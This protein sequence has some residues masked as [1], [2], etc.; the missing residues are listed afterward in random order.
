MK[1]KQK[2]LVVDD[3]ESFITLL[4]IGLQDENYEVDTAGNGISAL[5]RME[6]TSYDWLVSDIRMDE[7]DGIELAQ[8]VKER[9][10][11]TKIILMTAFD[12]PDRTGELEVEVVLE[13]PIH[14]EDLCK[15]INNGSK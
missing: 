14:V 2:L 6:N 11:Q 5:S 3:N 10:P 1:M 12:V 7:L 4:K 13:K 8:E 15:I 9:Y